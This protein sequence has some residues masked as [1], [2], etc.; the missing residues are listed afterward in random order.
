MSTGSKVKVSRRWPR[1]SCEILWSRNTEG[2]RT[3]TYT[4]IFYGQ[5]TSV[6]SVTSLH[7][8]KLTCCGSTTLTSVAAVAPVVLLLLSHLII[9]YRPFS[10]SLRRRRHVVLQP[11]E[12]FHFILVCRR[13]AHNETVYHEFNASSPRWQRPMPRPNWLKSDFFTQ[14]PATAI[15]F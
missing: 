10:R 3:E 8:I 12:L 11:V 7:S 2:I 4:D 14:I 5:A 15:W 9:S 13:A 1:K 6:R